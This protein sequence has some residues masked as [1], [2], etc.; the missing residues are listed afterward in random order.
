[1]QKN[2]L[3][4]FFLFAKYFHRQSKSATTAAAAAETVFL[5]F[6]NEFHPD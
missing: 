4:L 2:I 6:V 1:M 5:F 3:P